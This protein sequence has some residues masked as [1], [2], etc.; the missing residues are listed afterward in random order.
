M[1]MLLLRL[2]YCS[3]LHFYATAARETCRSEMAKRILSIKIDLLSAGGT[4]FEK[5]N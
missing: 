5:K 1:W 4:L 2:I 3:L